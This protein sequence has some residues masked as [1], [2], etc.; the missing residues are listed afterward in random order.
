MGLRFQ[1][2]GV[3]VMIIPSGRMISKVRVLSASIT[4]VDNIPK[5]AELHCD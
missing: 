4:G 3:R 1:K 2:E 5:S